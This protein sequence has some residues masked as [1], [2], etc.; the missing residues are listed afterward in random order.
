MKFDVIIGNPPYNTGV[1]GSGAAGTG[2]A[3]YHKFIN[4]AD[5]LLLE[6][7]YLCFVHPTT[8]RAGK[9]SNKAFQRAQQF[10]FDNQILSINALYKFPGVNAFVDFYLLKKNKNR[11]ATQFCNNDGTHY[12]MDIAADISIIRS[13]NNKMTDDIVKK[14]F[15]ARNNLLMRRPMGGLTRFDKTI[16]GRFPF[17]DGAAAAKQEWKYQKHPHIHQGNLK[18]I[19]ID[20]HKFRA[21]IDNGQLGI[22]DHVHYLLVDDME[23]ATFFCNFANSRLAR[24]SQKI[25]AD[26]WNDAT[27][28][29]TWNNPYPLSCVA[30]SKNIITDD[31]GFYQH[32]NLTQQEIEYVESM[33]K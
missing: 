1:V 11:V 24:F 5:D 6:D 8:W 22:G 20:N 23:E 16:C 25:F 4:L 29:V 15:S 14:V 31:S 28:D 17:A 7:G 32:F 9:K 18:V 2:R 26:T 12:Q 13:Y 10:L 27:Q 33:V 21:F 30:V 19:L 3:I